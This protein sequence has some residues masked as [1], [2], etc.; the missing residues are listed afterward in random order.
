LAERFGGPD[1][2]AALVKSSGMVH[3]HDVEVQAVIV[4]KDAALA[5]LLIPTSLPA[6]RRSGCERVLVFTHPPLAEGGKR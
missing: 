5:S 4:A 6:A 2:H 3:H 1:V